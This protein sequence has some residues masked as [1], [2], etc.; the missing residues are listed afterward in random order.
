M[1]N[2]RSLEANLKD[3]RAKYE[4]ESSKTTRFSYYDSGFSNIFEAGIG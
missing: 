1:K 3:I 4:G 2:G